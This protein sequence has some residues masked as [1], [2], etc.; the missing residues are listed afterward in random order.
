[1]APDLSLATD[2]LADT[3]F[4]DECVIY[5]Q[6][7]SAGTLDRSTGNLAPVEPVRMYEGPCHIRKQQGQRANQDGPQPH[8]D[9]EHLVRLRPVDTIRPGMV[10]RIRRRDQQEF[11]EFRV[12]RVP[13]KSHRIT[14]HVVVTRTT[15]LPTPAAP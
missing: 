11:H 15:A 14:T 8:V 9:D 12:I 3:F 10:L 7:R 4:T 1:M 5:E 6:R 2:A 13:V